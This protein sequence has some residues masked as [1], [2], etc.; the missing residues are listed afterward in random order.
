MAKSIETDRMIPKPMSDTFSF[1]VYRPKTAFLGQKPLFL[2]ERSCI[3]SHLIA[4][5]SCFQEEVLQSK[6]V[7]KP[8]LKN[9]SK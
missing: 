4:K 8:M 9:L 2:R 7:G 1:S 3:V 5:K 6:L